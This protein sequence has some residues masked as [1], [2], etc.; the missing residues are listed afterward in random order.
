MGVVLRYHPMYI[1][2]L[3]NVYL[4]I[5]EMHGYKEAGVWHGRTLGNDSTLKEQ[6]REMIKLVAPLRGKELKE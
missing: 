2:R 3:A 6:V 4:D 1:E 5:Y